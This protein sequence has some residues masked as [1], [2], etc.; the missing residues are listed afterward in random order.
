MNLCKKFVPAFFF[1]WET[2]GL[3]CGR[4]MCYSI[5]WKFQKINALPNV[6]HWD[7][8]VPYGILHYYK[9][10]KIKLI[11]KTR[12]KSL[13]VGWFLNFS[14]VFSLPSQ[15]TA[16]RRISFIPWQ[17]NNGVNIWPIFSVGSVI[18]L[19]TLGRMKGAVC[20]HHRED[21]VSM[22][23]DRQNK[24]ISYIENTTVS[25]EKDGQKCSCRT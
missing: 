10:V 19:P 9:D 25:K 24:W 4:C 18:S 20:P 5:K 12:W 13:C 16:N 23:E 14:V 1:M 7:F 22:L 21:K 6:N 11:C 8:R 17:K 15:M 2:H 3:K